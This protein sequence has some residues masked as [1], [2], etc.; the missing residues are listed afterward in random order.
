MRIQDAE[1]C[2]GVGIERFGIHVLAGRDAIMKGRFVSARSYDNNFAFRRCSRI[3]MSRTAN[4]IRMN[5]VKQHHVKA[6]RLPKSRWLSMYPEK[7]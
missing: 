5:L 4:I 6:Y 2:V 7:A 1:R 3:T